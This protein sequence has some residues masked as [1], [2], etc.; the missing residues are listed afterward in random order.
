MTITPQYI[1]GMI[2]V[3]GLAQLIVLLA[4][5]RLGVISFWH[6]GKCS[7]HD[8]FC[9]SFKE[10]KASFKVVRD[11][12]MLNAQIIEQHDK[13]LEEGKVVFESIQKAITQIDKNVALIKLKLKIEEE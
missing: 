13:K 11:E 5:K 4:L 7:E 3:F 1:V 10:M 6:G 8:S 2:V 12:H 9:R